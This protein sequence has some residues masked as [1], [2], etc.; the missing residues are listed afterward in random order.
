MV[1]RNFKRSYPYLFCSSVW[2]DFLTVPS[3]FVIGGIATYTLA[4]LSSE[5]ISWVDVFDN[6]LVYLLLGSCAL[7]CFYMAMSAVIGWVLFG[8]IRCDIDKRG[9]NH[10]FC[11]QF[12]KNAEYK[13]SS[14]GLKVSVA[15]Q[16]GSIDS[17]PVYQSESS[18]KQSRNVFIKIVLPKDMIKNNKNRLLKYYA[19]FS[20]RFGVF[21]ISR[22]FRV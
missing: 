7:I 18:M 5:I 15:K 6:I 3:M 9:V 13:V 21:F 1:S 20:F 14:I 10:R 8:Y 4:I 16:V 17:S 22:V 12:K 11:F 2:F 19:F